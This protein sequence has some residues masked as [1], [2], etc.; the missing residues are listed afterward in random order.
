M[1]RSTRFKV[2]AVPNVIFD[3][4][5][6]VLEWKPRSI[7]EGYY[8]DPQTR[9]AMLE[10]LFAH[11]DWLHLDRGTLTEEDLLANVERRTGRSQ[12]ELK[13]L[14]AASLDS[15]LPKADTVALIE[16]LAERQIPLYCLSN[17]SGGTYKHLREKHAFWT[18]F[19]GIVISGEIQMM[20]PEPEIFEYLLRRYELSA[21]ETLFIDDNLPNI[22]AAQALGLN[23]IWFQDAGQCGAELERWL[24]TQ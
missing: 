24:G 14:F 10:A 16:R 7:L 18:A 20:K 17:M 1:E 19:R 12:A 23:T 13:G 6:V 9:A 21:S 2:G 4:G 8:A 11:P 5:G 3:L 15:L 22:E